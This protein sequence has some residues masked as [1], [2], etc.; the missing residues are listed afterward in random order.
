MSNGNWC[1][2]CRVWYCNCACEHLAGDKPDYSDQWQDKPLDLDKWLLS[3]NAP[4][5][6]YVNPY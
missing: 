3:C 2:V 1:S 4:D 6:A 5:G